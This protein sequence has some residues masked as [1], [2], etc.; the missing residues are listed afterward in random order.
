ML[1]LLTGRRRFSL[2]PGMAFLCL[3][4]LFTGVVLPAACVI[5]A[6]PRRSLSL[7]TGI[8]VRC[9][10]DCKLPIVRVASAQIAST[11]NGN[12]RVRTA[13]KHGQRMDELSCKFVFASH[14]KREH[15]IAPFSHFRAMCP[16]VFLY[17]CNNQPPICSVPVSAGENIPFCEHCQ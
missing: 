7:F 13:A 14:L 9:I 8:S 12:Q 4:C 11:F 10:C 16:C 2:V 5:C 15:V 3:Q 17:G 1:P 6:P